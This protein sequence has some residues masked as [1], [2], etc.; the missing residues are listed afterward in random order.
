[1]AVSGGYVVFGE[2][3]R[4]YSWNGTTNVRKL[5]IDVVPSQLL[6]TGATLYFTLGSPQAIYKV[7][8]N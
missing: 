1:L 4:V 3:G 6:M 7:A 8:V 5:I 2:D